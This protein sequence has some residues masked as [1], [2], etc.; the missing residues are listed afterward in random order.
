MRLTKT[1][2]AEAVNLFLH[3]EQA[4]GTGVRKV[5]H[6]PQ[7]PLWAACPW[8][9]GLEA[10]PSRRGR[11]LQPGRGLPLGA[12]PPRG[13]AKTP[14][15]GWLSDLHKKGLREWWKPCH[16][17]PSGASTPTANP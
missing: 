11:G 17:L 8:L 6:G 2:E 12:W 9:R 5:P 16:P 15:P 14:A 7:M 10:W 4:G 13:P 3:K 1:T